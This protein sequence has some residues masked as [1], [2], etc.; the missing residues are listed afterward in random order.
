MT[1]DL[2]VASPE[3]FFVK[4][5]SDDNLQA[6]TQQLPGVEQVVRVIP[7]TMGDVAE[8]GLD[9]GEE[10]DD[11]QVAELFNNH[12]A[13]VVEDDD[14]EVTEEMITEDM[15]GFGKEPLIQA[16][17]LASGF[18]S[19][20]AMNIEQMQQLAELDGDKLGNLMALAESQAE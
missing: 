12:W 19:Q 17:L 2:E 9:E 8:Y 4:R 15:I 10:L 5:D 11:A 20:Q 16:I 7:M 18:A 1:E 13:D 14:F 6:V 3:D